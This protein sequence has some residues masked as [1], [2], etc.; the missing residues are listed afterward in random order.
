MRTLL[1]VFQDYFVSGQQDVEFGS[2]S[3]VEFVIADDLTALRIA[4]IHNLTM[5]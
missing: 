1:T 2:L 3:F 4:Q 5:D